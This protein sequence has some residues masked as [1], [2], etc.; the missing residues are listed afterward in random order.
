MSKSPYSAHPFE[1]TAK[2]RPSPWRLI[3]CSAVLVA[4]D[5]LLGPQ[6]AISVFFVL[7]VISA[8][9]Y[10]GL[11][12]ACVLAATFSLMR[13][14]SNWAWGF[15]MSMDTALV[16]NVMRAVTLMLVA[17]LTEQL[18]SQMRKLKKRQALL[19]ACLPVCPQC[20]VAC[21]HDGQ[22]LPIQHA[23]PL[24][25]TTP[26]GSLCPECERKGYDMQTG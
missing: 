18:A 16:N 26:P 8:A 23:Q 13:F 20:G 24:S 14:M 12:F 10:Q 2:L 21:R 1:P 22:W 11:R 9:W 4:L 5:F 17:F 6:Y 3:A 19:E 7:P 15:P 25:T